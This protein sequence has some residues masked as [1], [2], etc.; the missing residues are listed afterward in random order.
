MRMGAYRVLAGLA[1][2]GGL[3]AAGQPAAA[4]TAATLARPETAPAPDRLHPDRRQE[5][6]ARAVGRMILLGFTGAEPGDRGPAAIAAMIADG[7]L[8]GVVLFADNVRS[9]AQVRR[10]SDALTGPLAGLPPF[11]AIDQEGGQI[12]RLPRRKGFTGLPSARALAARD[13][14]VA[15]ALYTRTATEL[16]ALGINVNLGPVVDLDLNPA[17]PAIGRK[18]R[19]YA[20]NPDTVVAF[21]RAFI[22]AH[23]RLGILTSAKHFPG[24]G[25]AIGDSHDRPVDISA[26]WQADEL[27]PYRA[28]IAADPPALVMVGHLDHPLFSD[29][30][31]PASLSRRTLTE[32][33]RRKLGFQGL[34]VTDDLGMGAVTSRWPVEEAAV[35][36]IRAGAD[37]VLV[38]NRE[39]PDPYIADRIIAAVTAA[40]AAGRIPASA[41]ADADRRILAARNA[42]VA[43]RAAWGPPACPAAPARDAALPAG[44]TRLA[45]GSAGGAATP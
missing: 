10:L 3:L 18:G 43:A 8:G 36:A 6:V 19:A 30:D 37:L 33:L 29:G 38:A 44:G 1:V 23:R 17:S 14:A 20:R 7:R 42:I 27:D 34:I 41:I 9:P 4:S 31:R 21:A 22:D 13:L 26:T 39:H 16:A 15:C 12:Q 45:I 5:L 28:L 35:M 40:V 11:I 25:S 24:H 32:A 2:L